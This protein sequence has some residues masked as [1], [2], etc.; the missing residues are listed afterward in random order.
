MH[1]S[2][3][4]DTPTVLRI[5]VST[6]NSQEAIIS[7]SG[8]FTGEYIRCVEA[9]IADVPQKNQSILLNLKHVGVVDR[10]SMSFLRSLGDRDIRL[11]QCPAYVL[12]WMDQDC[13]NCS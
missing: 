9:A 5:D 1:Y 3:A 10:E 13:R 12:R 11:T 6:E 8:N 7:L 4:E 2:F